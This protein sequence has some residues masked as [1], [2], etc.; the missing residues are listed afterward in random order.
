MNNDNSLNS[1]A[2]AAC[3]TYIASGSV[4]SANQLPIP[5]LNS[6][7]GSASTIVGDFIQ[8]NFPT[9]DA[10]VLGLSTVWNFLFV[11]IQINVNL[12]I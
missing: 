9:L 10:T 3:N 11:I 2:V 4:T 5:A 8:V 1:R 7:S 6:I 12:I